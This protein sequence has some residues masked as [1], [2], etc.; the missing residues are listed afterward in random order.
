MGTIISR[1]KV[2]SVLIPLLS[3]IGC[4]FADNRYFLREYKLGAPKETTVGNLMLAW[5]CGTKNFFYGSAVR[6][7]LYYSGIEQNIIYMNCRRQALYSNGYVGQ[8]RDQEFKYDISNSR[9]V[10]IEDVILHVAD[11]DQQKIRYTV[12]RGPTVEGLQR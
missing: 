10:R 11:A 7:E 3:I 1:W 2:I 4:G 12:F 5:E 6:K 8:P 9:L